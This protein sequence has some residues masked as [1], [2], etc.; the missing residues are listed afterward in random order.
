[1]NNRC[2]ELRQAKGLSQIELAVYAGV[3]M[4]PVASL[5]KGKIPTLALLIKIAD[6][7]GVSAAELYPRL[8]Q[9]PAKEA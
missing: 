1:M 5:E 6:A 9:G 3:S 8:A 2:L 7:L 4:S